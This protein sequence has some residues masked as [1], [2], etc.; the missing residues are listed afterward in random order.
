MYITVAVLDGSF[1][2]KPVMTGIK[3]SE[4]LRNETLRIKLKVSG[5]KSAEEAS[6]TPSSFGKVS[7]R[8]GKGILPKFWLHG[9]T[10]RIEIAADTA[11]VM[12]TA[13]D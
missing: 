3:P 10:N 6:R 7:G 11:R 2:V 12:G 4:T 5:K 1:S 9:T 13:K 8:Q